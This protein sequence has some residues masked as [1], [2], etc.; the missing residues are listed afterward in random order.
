MDLKNKIN[1][2]VEE[3]EDRKKIYG[4]IANDPNLSPFDHGFVCGFHILIK[5][6]S[7]KLRQIL[8]N[9]NSNKI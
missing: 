1:R 6:I 8:E 2:L 7:D 4:L 3:L 5:E 9:S